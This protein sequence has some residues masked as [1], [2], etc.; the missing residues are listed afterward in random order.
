MGMCSKFSCV[1]PFCY[2][3]QSEFLPVWCDPVGPT[4][5]PKARDKDSNDLA[6]RE[7]HF[8]AGI[9]K[10][11]EVMCLQPDRSVVVRTLRP[12][13]AGEPAAAK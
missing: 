8:D 2:K 7:P 5:R 10:L 9:P 13:F 4:I 11:V 12:R 3:V 6:T 1:V